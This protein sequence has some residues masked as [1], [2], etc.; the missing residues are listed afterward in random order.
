[1]ERSSSGVTLER[2]LFDFQDHEMYEYH[3]THLWANHDFVQFFWGGLPRVAC[4]PKHS[5]IPETLANKR[6]R[7]TSPKSHIGSAGP[8]P[9][10]MASSDEELVQ[11]EVSDD[12][13]IGIPPLPRSPGKR[14]VAKSA[15]QRVA[16]RPSKV[17]AGKKS[18]LN[19]GKVKSLEE[20]PPGSANCRDPCKRII[21]NL[22]SSFERARKKDVFDDMMK[23][24]TARKKLIRAYIMKCGVPKGMRGGKKKKE[25][26]FCALQF[27][28]EVRV[29]EQLVRDGVYEMM[30]EVAFMSHAAKPKHYPPTGLDQESAKSEFLKLSRETNAIVDFLGPTQK[31]Q[32]RVGIKVKTLVTHR[33]L[34]AKAQAYQLKDKEKKK[35]T[36]AEVNAAYNR[37][38]KDMAE[39]GGAT[40][41]LSNID[42]LKNLASAS[43]RDGGAFDGDQ[44]SL[45]DIG[46]VMEYMAKNDARHGEEEEEVAGGENEE[47]DDDNDAMTEGS[48]RTATGTGRGKSTKRQASIVSAEGSPVEKKLKKVWFDRDS[49]IADAMRKQEQWLCNIEFGQCQH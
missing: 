20:F 12:E 42:V 13:V 44:F 35:A 8:S 10:R 45:T 38:Y 39:V 49:K 33:S 9:L 7:H 24:E 32:M 36:Q 15:R 25:A 31:Y 29:E 14:T 37:L 23:D 2:I 48:S 34:T 21:D 11:D 18:C 1:M 3:G 46:S 30:H 22:R 47:E 5:K 28:Q 27:L 43:D 4:K 16:G 19:C 40:N 26:L 17:Q 41:A 6:Q